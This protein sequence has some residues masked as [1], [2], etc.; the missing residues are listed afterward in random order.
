MG[1]KRFSGMTTAIKPSLGSDGVGAVLGDGGPQLLNQLG[2]KGAGV[3]QG[4]LEPRDT[5]RRDSMSLTVTVWW[6]AL[7]GVM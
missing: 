2:H 6:P 4:G 7:D 5:E 3:M 1:K